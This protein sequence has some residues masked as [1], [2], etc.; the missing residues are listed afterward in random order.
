MNSI[1]QYCYL[2]GRGAALDAVMGISLPSSSQRHTVQRQEI[3][4]SGALS[5]DWGRLL[6][7]DQDWCTLRQP[8][9]APIYVALREM[10]G[11]TRKSATQS[12]NAKVTRLSTRVGLPNPS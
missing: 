2:Q 12:A 6:K 8:Q 7:L 11:R 10:D 5:R 3:R 1:E 9:S 4:T